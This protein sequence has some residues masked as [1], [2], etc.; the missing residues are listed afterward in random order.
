M[1][2]ANTLPPPPGSDQTPSSDS[3]TQGATAAPPMPSPQSSQGTQLL[4][5]VVNNLRAI[6]KAY[7]GAAPKVAEMN[8]LAREIAQEI[9]KAAPPSEAQAPP[10]GGQ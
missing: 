1:A 4:I 8:N 6:A 9:M 7:P 5:S 3:P 2:S 10:V